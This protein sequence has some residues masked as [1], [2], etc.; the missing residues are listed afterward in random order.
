MARK[1]RY[2]EEA[3]HKAGVGTKRHR[4]YRIRVIVASANF[5]PAVASGRAKYDGDLWLP[6]LVDAHS[7][8]HTARASPARHG[9]YRHGSR[10]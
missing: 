4:M 2:D 7:L 10:T 5:N 8:D 9:K 3:L 1:G 6:T